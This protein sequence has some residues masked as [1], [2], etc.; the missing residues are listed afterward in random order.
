MP[1]AFTPPEHCPVCGEA[2]PRNARACPGCGA[3][4]RTGWNDDEADYGGLDLPDE[5]FD[6]EKFEDEEF[7]MR[8]KKTISQKLWLGVGL[9]VLAVM[10]LYLIRNFL[11]HG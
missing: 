2:V 11:P 7:G 5:T 9:V 10:T 3:D 8:R 4:E 1:D 6:R